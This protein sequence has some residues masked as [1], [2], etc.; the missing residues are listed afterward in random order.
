[1]DTALWIVAWLLAVMY[2]VSGV[3]K[4]FVPREKIA[5]VASGAGWVLD[6]SPGAVKAI[7]AV[8]IL[9]AVGLILPALLDIAPVLVPLAA[10]GLALVM[11]GAVVLR[12][13]RHEP[14][15]A[16]LDLGYLALC[17]FVAIGHA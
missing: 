5:G 9:G 17:A 2:L 12:I 7:G 4:L 3:G 16:L 14:K 1:M 11:A 15:V 10:L 6:F 8:E 13:R